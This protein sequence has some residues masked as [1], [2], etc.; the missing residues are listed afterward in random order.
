MTDAVQMLTGLDEIALLGE[1]VGE[2]CH[3]ARDY[4]G[5][6]KAQR[7]E[8]LAQQFT[9]TLSIARTALAS[10]GQKLPEFVPSD[11]CSDKAGPMAENLRKNSLRKP[12]PP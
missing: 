7:R 8:E 1:F 6:S 5:Y 11:D 10:I 12:Q 2:L 4:L 9:S 3:G